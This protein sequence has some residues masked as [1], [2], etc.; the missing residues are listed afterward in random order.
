MG[1]QH[2]SNNDTHRAPVSVSAEGQSR[3][4]LRGLQP[5]PLVPWEEVEVTGR[6]WPGSLSPGSLPLG[7]LSPLLTGLT[8]WTSGTISA[9][10]ELPHR[11]ARDSLEPDGALP[12][13]VHDDERGCASGSRSR[14]LSGPADA[15]RG[16]TADSAAVTREDNFFGGQRLALGGFLRRSHTSVPLSYKMGPERWGQG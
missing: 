9:E 1:R 11:R 5:E 12:D 2:H 16:V 8:R 4:G 6:L 15:A 3:R 10:G 7:S 13:T 14:L